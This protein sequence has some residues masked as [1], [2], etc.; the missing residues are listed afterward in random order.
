MLSVNIDVLAKAYFFLFGFL[1]ARLDLAVAR[2][3]GLT[4][5]KENRKWEM[6]YEKRIL[7][8]MNE[9]ASFKIVLPEK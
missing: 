5:E 4:E 7:K 6:K 3:V 2:R 1:M 8:A 9:T